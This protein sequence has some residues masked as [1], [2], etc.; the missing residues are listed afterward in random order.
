MSHEPDEIIL[1][2]PKCGADVGY[3]ETVVVDEGES[4]L[5][6]CPHCGEASPTD[7]WFE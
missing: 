3:E 2:C 1:E 4:D 7:D 5:V 6:G